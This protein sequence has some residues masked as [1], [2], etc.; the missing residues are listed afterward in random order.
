MTKKETVAAEAAW[1]KA[2]AEGRVVRLN[3]DRLKA[4]KTAGEAEAFAMALPAGFNAE[5][6]LVDDVVR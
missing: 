6:V 3:G 5:I 2:L 4:F 1:T